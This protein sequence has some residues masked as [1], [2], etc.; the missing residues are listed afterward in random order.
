MIFLDNENDRPR[1]L[2]RTKKCD[3]KYISKFVTKHRYSLTKHDDNIRLSVKTIELTLNVFW[4]L[5]KKA[6]Q[7]AGE[8][9]AYR[10]SS[11]V[12]AT[13]A[14][15]STFVIELDWL[16]NCAGFLHHYIIVRVSIIFQKD[17]RTN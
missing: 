5:N 2:C 13:N 17:S 14:E 7:I 6:K 9:A 1:L 4:I 3:S 8:C 11:K 16:E 12:C 10:N 15:N